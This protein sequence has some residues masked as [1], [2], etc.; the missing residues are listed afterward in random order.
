MF[1]IGDIRVVDFSLEVELG[2]FERVVG[3]QDEEKLE[4]AALVVIV[5]I[6]GSLD[7]KVR[8]GSQHMESPLGRLG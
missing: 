3:W 8:Q 2:R 5:S 7:Q 6:R 4:L 1:V